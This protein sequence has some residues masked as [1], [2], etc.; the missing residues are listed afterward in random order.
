MCSQP[1]RSLDLPAIERELRGR[2][3]GL[4]ERLAALSRPPERGAG[5]QFGKRV[6]DGTPETVA[7]L[8]DVGVGGSPQLSDERVLRALAKLQDGSYGTCDVC[9]KPIAEGRLKARPD[10]VLCINCAQRAR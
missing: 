3:A 5:L 9:G 6:D 10:S 7:R 2:H 1:G 8:T 4:K